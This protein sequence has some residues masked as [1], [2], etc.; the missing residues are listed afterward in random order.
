MDRSIPA[1][2]DAQWAR[3][4]RMN[5]ARR[6]ASRDQLRSE[7]IANAVKLGEGVTSGGRLQTWTLDCRGLLLTQRQLRRFAGALWERLEVYRPQLVAG[8]TLSADPLIV[9][10]MYEAQRHGHALDGMIVR[11]KP[12]TY[13]TRKAFEAP[14]LHAGVNAIVVDDVLNSGRAIRQVISQLDEIGARISAVGV[15]VSF[16]DAGVMS[17]LEE[18]GIALQALFSQHDL[19]LSMG[20]HTR[21]GSFHVSRD[22]SLDAGWLDFAISADGTIYRAD[23]DGTIEALDYGGATVW[24][25]RAPFEAFAL[26]LASR[27]RVLLAIGRSAAILALNADSGEELWSTAA[28][29]PALHFNWVVIDRFLA[30]AVLAGDGAGSVSVYGLSKGDLLRNI[31]YD[32]EGPRLTVRAL[33]TTT[34]LLASGR[35]LLAVDVVSGCADDVKRCDAEVLDVQCDGNGRAVLVH[36]HELSC[37]QLGSPLR[38]LWRSPI[39]QEG[40]PASVAIGPRLVIVRTGRSHVVGIETASGRRKWIATLDQQLTGTPILAG[41]NKVV[42]QSVNGRLYLFEV[43]T[44]EFL[45]STDLDDGVVKS[46]TIE[47]SLTDPVE[48]VI[49]SEQRLLGFALAVNPE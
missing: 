5:D 43:E 47:P 26:E 24:K 38:Q 2:L 49:V 13:G 46:G 27:E 42:V 44:G 35:S 33:D 14:L 3:T 41:K 16:D 12:K 23:R 22:Q 20:F 39:V 30:V 1:I 45:C 34:L 6:I 19:G 48:L 37:V 8:M 7:L 36:A 28:V 17:F 32:A 10:L 18:R 11:N 15:L 40:D 25:Q 31:P 29:E 4:P 9:A 21:R